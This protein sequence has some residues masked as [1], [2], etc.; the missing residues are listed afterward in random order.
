MKSSRS[1]STGTPNGRTSGVADEAAVGVDRQRDRDDPVDGNLAPLVDRRAVGGQDDVAVE[2]QPP[3]AR[4]ADLL[5]AL[6]READDVAILLDDRLGHARSQGE[7]RL[8]GH[9]PR[10]A[11]DRDEDLRADP[12]VHLRQ[13]GA[14]GM[15]RDMDVEPGAR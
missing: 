15:A 13:L 3:D 10:L 9:V 4:L 14:A 8:L 12:V 5:R 7:A 2:H 1:S 11:V 6:G